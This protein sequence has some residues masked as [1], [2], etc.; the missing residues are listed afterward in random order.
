M[1]AAF[2]LRIQRESF[3][4]SQLLVR[5]P[6]GMILLGREKKFAK[7]ATPRGN[8]TDAAVSLSKQP[9]HGSLS[10]GSTTAAH[11][12]TGVLNTPQRGAKKAS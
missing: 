12:V 2:L 11:H 5:Y 7:G 1:T 9:G 3:I 8:Q 10:P 6:G 4:C